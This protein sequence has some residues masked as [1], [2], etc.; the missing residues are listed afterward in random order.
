MDIR[1]GLKLGKIAKKL[2]MVA[3]VAA[4]ATVGTM[5]VGG[6]IKAVGKVEEGSTADKVIDFVS[7]VAV[8]TACMMVL[9]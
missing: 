6:V 7:D 2:P 4:V 8:N 1:K 9:L 5:A 3:G